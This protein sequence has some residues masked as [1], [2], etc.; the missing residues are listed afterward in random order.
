M[1]VHDKSMLAVTFGGE[2]ATTE[3]LSQPKQ[4]YTLQPETL[5]FATLSTVP[6]RNPYTRH[7]QAGH[8]KTNQTKCVEWRATA[9]IPCAWCQM[10][11]ATQPVTLILRVWLYLRR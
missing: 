10:I 9:D 1:I 8:I 11:S 2:W 4:R 7:L 5:L 3:I 6:E